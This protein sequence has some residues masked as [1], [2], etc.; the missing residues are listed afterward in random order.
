M[1][2]GTKDRRILVKYIYFLLI[3][4]LI[5]VALDLIFYF[6]IRGA[7]ETTAIVFACVTNV[8][9]IYPLA[10]VLAY[11]FKK[12]DMVRLD[13]DVLTFRTNT[14]KVSVPLS[15]IMHVGKYPRT[16][17]PS[18]VVDTLTIVLKNNKTYMVYPVTDLDEVV[19][20]IRKEMYRTLFENPLDTLE[21]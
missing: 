10:V 7:N 8:L 17:A 21:K 2:I 1:V 3:S 19:T 20:A 18:L 13:G 4:I 16:L 6:S 14:G 5:V 12:D 15:A 9:F 11:A